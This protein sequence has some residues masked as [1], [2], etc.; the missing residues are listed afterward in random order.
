MNQ[1]PSVP[2]GCPHRLGKWV[3]RTSKSTQAYRDGQL[4]LPEHRGGRLVV[5]ATG[6]TGELGHDGQHRTDTGVTWR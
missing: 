1:L 6:C 4:R 3:L 2:A 5:A